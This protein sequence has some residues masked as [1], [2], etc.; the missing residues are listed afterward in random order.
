[1][2]KINRA[3]TMALLGALVVAGAAL[4]TAGA[5]AASTLGVSRTAPFTNHAVFLQ[6]DNPS[7][8]QILAYDQAA[9][10]TLTPA[11]TYDTGGTGV[12]PPARPPTP[13]PPRAPWCWPT[14]AASSWP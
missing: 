6:S 9:N 13:W 10:G 5:A 2:K 1:M 14:G 4:G 3:T 8:N 11:G 7:G 12:W